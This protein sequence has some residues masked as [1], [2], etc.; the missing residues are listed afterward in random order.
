MKFLDKK[1]YI[2]LFLLIILLFECKVLA[3]DNEIQYTR[4][5]ISNYFLG[6]ISV[7][8]DNN[9]EAFKYLKKVKSLKNEH[10]KFNTEFIRTLVLLEKFNQAFAFSKSIWNE[11]EL[12]FEADLLLGLNFF[13]KKDYIN[14]EKHF[15]RLNE[16]SQYNLFFKDFIGNVLMAWSKASQG[17][18]E[19]S[20]KFIEKVPTSY[21]H[22][23]KI[24][25]SLL[26]CYFNTDKTQ[27]YFEKLIQ[28]ENYNFSRYNFFLT[29]YLLFN[30]KIM[31]AKKVIKNSRKEYNSNLLIKQ[32]ENFFFK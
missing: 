15:E 32:T 1:I 10:S 6:I 28:D 5:N 16:I 3:K 24:Q 17:D 30:N 13:I 19:G 11:D 14:A 18:K 9:N 23:T 2:T 26:Q 12:F 31:E 22:L 29:N 4:E 25:N 27:K 21:G 8:Q 7:N 20:F